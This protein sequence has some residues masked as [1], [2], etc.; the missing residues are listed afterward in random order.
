MAYHVETG[1]VEALDEET[2]PQAQ[3]WLLQEKKRRQRREGD[4]DSCQ[5]KNATDLQ[6]TT[7]HTQ[8]D[9]EPE[10]YKGP[11][12]MTLSLAGMWIQGQWTA[13]SKS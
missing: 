9:L 13:H 12:G 3:E 4:P 7:H 11:H 1:R 2:Q 6:P 5:N 8:S 10:V